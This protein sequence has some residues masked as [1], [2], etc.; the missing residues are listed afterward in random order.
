MWSRFYLIKTDFRQKVLLRKVTIH[1]RHGFW[2][3]VSIDYRENYILEQLKKIEK[4]QRRAKKFS[5]PVGVASKSVG[6]IS[7]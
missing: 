7:P 5:T 2:L 4:V 3:F 6:V 1:F